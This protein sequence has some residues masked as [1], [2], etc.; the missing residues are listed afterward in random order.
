MQS[1]QLDYDIPEV[2]IE[3]RATNMDT[4]HNKYKRFKQTNP[5]ALVA[6]NTRVD[7][8]TVLYWN[9]SRVI[10]CSLVIVSI[11]ATLVNNLLVLREF[12]T[13]KKG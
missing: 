12:D 2:Q 3:E 5:Q 6:M 7:V 9:I 13:T 4:W 8:E 1:S 10:F 11:L